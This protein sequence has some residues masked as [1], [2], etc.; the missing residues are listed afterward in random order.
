M[1]TS[2]AATSRRTAASASRRRSRSGLGTPT[3]WT[4]SYFH[5]TGGRHPRLRDSVAVQRPG[6]VDRN[7]YYG[8]TGRQLSADLRRHRHGQSR[9]RFQQ[10]RHASQPVALRELRARRADHRAANPRRRDARDA[11]QRDDG[12]PQRDR[13]E[14]RRDI[15][16]RS[17]RPDRDFETGFIDHTLVTGVEAGR[18]TS[19]PTRP[20][21]TQ[22]ADD[23]S[24]GSGSRPAFSGTDDDLVRCAHDSAQRRR[25]CARHRELGSHWDYRR[26]ALGPLRR[27]LHPDR[28]R[29][30]R[31]STAWTK[32]RLGAAAL[33]YK[34][35]PIGSIYFAAGTSFNP[36]A[37]SLSLSASNANL[38]PEKNRTYEV[39]TK[40]DLAHDKLSL[41]SAL[42]RTDKTNAREPDPNNPLL[43]V[44]AGNQRVDGVAA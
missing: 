25:V 35:V 27:R 20:T 43:N 33:V 19:D 29:R 16:R 44:L 11:A 15:S 26:R 7:N 40:W 21:Y 39:G 28:S 37:E 17:T 6:A 4:F 42:F 9:A 23:Q 38:P 12:E 2:R 1:R 22:C 31:R 36:S 5:Q 30:R 24:A 34:P 3:R 13:V 10:S 32:C 41:R 18:E 8:F 14:Q